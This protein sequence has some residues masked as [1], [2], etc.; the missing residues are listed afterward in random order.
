[1]VRNMEHLN[2]LEGDTQEQTNELRESTE[3]LIN[4]LDDLN[5][6]IRRGQT[7]CGISTPRFRR[8]SRMSLTI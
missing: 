5:T 8:Q 4:T 2:E 3:D 1:M 7:L 6:A